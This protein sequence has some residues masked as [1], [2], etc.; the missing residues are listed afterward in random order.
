MPTIRALRERGVQL[1]MLTNSLGT[2]DEIA[3]NAHYA[4]AR[5]EMVDLGVELKE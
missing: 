1:R 4:N 2:A 3:V 5:P